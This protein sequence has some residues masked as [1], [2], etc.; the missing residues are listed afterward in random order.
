MAINNANSSELNTQS[1]IF[2]VT[3]IEATRCWLVYQA[4]GLFAQRGFA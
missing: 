2:A 1:L 4:I 3:T